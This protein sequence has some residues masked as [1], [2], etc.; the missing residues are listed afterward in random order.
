[1]K[2]ILL[3]TAL[4]SLLATSA[5]AVGVDLSVGACPGDA[6]ASADAGS[7][8]CAGGTNVTVLATFMPA[9]DISDLVELDMIFDLVVDGDVSTN[10]TFWDF[11]TVNHSAIS[12]HHERPTGGCSNYTDVWNVDGGGAVGGVAI[13]LPSKVRI[14]AISYRPTKAAV[15]ANQRLFGIQLVLDTHQAIEGTGSAPGCT[16]GVCMVLQRATPVSAGGL[17]TTTLADPSV[18]G[19]QSTFNGGSDSMCFAVPAV[20][21]TWGQLKSLYR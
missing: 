3:A 7:L 11:E 16:R 8:D 2:R 10:A 18:F 15:L 9:E 20:R 1:M 21:H 14:G 13:S 4:L 12:L 17:P 5:F 19:N 6:G